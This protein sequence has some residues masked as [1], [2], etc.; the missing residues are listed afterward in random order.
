MHCYVVKN[1]LIYGILGCYGICI[2]RVVHFLNFFIL[3]FG[4]LVNIQKAI[5]FVQ[6]YSE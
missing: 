5:N 2:T 1:A 3:E 6:N 4:C